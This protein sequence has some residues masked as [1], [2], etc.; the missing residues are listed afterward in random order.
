[1]WPLVLLAI[2]ILLIIYGLFTTI[3]LD[4]NSRKI[5][6]AS[7][8]SLFR[9]EYSFDDF[10]RFL[11]VRKTTNLVYAGTDVRMQLNVRNQSRELNLRSFQKTNKIERFLEETRSILE[12]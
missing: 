9:K 11:I 5:V 2:P 7:F 6:R 4:K 10:V 1:M 12:R 8:G 3:S